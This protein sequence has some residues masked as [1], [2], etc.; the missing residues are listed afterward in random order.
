[1]TMNLVAQRFWVVKC[2]SVVRR[3]IK[4]C[5]RCRRKFAKPQEQ[6]VA[7]LRS[8]GLQLNTHPFACTE[9]DYFGHFMIQINRSKV[10]SDMTASL[11]V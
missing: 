8:A 7:D 3:V 2:T 5:M 10:R 6:I 4:D 1:M 9:V 11:L